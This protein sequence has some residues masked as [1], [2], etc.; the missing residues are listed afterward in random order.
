MT[1]WEWQTTK[2]RPDSYALAKRTGRIQG[3]YVR[4]RQQLA[5]ALKD[6]LG[7]LVH[8]GP[9]GSEVIPDPLGSAHSPMYDGEK[10]DWAKQVGGRPKLDFDPVRPG[11]RY[12]VFVLGAGASKDAGFP[13]CTDFF[14]ENY[15][16]GIGMSVEWT[17]ESEASLRGGIE[18]AMMEVYESDAVKFDRLRRFYERVLFNADSRF[19]NVTGEVPTMQW[20]EESRHYFLLLGLILEAAASG[21]RVAVIS[22]NHDLCVEELL[23][24]SG[25][26]Y[27]TLTAR[28]HGVGKYPGLP[29]FGNDFVLL[30]LHG[31]FNFAHCANCKAIWCD[32]QW[33]WDKGDRWPCAV[34]GSENHNFYV[35]PTVTKNVSALREAWDDARVVLQNAEDV[36]V[37]GYSMPEYDAHAVELLKG[38][39]GDANLAVVDPYSQNV[40]AK[41]SFVHPSRRFHCP[42]G[43]REFTT[44]LMYDDW[45]FYQ[46][47]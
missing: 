13:I 27:G 35:P 26:N 9:L 30:K 18:R 43:V 45:P 44:A 25:F 7:G 1:P 15:L 29:D 37:V 3:D 39:S 2:Y 41:F 33:V 36:F 11:E 10:S 38:I 23:R 17:P 31:S 12:T 8:E 34:C 32:A 24:M 4:A 28:M 16:A 21:R 6:I 40:A 5:Q 47:E 19:L 22:F 46:F 20:A 14:N 42:M